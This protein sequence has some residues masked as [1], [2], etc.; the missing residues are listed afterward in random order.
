[1]SDHERMI[2]VV[3]E[4]GAD[5]IAIAWEVVALQKRVDELEIDRNKYRKY[6]NKRL[7]ASDMPFKKKGD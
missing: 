6:F 2:A 5:P 7:T 4:H 3:D 1:M